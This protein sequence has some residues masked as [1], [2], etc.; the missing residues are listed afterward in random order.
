MTF[1]DDTNTAAAETGA[2]VSTPIAIVSIA[3]GVV[4]TASSKDAPKTPFTATA[5][6]EDEDPVPEVVDASE[7]EVLFVK[8]VLDGLIE[9]RQLF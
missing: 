9:M 5:A 8:H 2:S 1:G 4:G 6:D 3:N 7:S